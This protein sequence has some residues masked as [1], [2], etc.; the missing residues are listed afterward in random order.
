MKIRKAVAGDFP[1]VLELNREIQALHAKAEPSLFKPADH[2]NLSAERFR[3]S[4][5][6]PELRIYVA[7]TEQGAAA[8][9]VFAETPVRA[10]SPYRFP[11]RILYV[12]HL[13]VGHAHRGRGVGKRLMAH[14]V[15][16][17]K[18]DGFERI[19]LDVWSF[20]RSARAFYAAAGFLTFNERMSLGL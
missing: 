11:A 14:L 10:E 7:E 3:A 17:A 13:G 16:Q 20:N 6:D 15:E 8:G 19:E 18:R 2:L 5:A 4:V 1:L 9:Y 12:H